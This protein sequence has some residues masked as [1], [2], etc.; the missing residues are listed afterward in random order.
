MGK[1]KIIFFLETIADLGL[2]IASKIQLNE[3]MK[4]SKCQ[5]SRPF[6]DLSS[7]VP[8]LRPFAPNDL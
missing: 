5:R 3:L 8:L 2:K 6:F 4:L 7:L 1:V